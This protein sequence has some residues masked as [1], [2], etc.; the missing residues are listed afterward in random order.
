TGAY[1]DLVRTS[2]EELQELIEA[3][4]IPE[5]SFFRDRGAFAALRS[6]VLDRQLPNAPNEPLRILSVPCS[7]G[8]EPYT[9]AMTLLD[10][11][12][13]ATCARVDAVDISARALAHAKHGFF[14]ANA[15]RGADLAFRDRYFTPAGARYR[16]NDAVRALVQFQ[17]GNLLALDVVTGGAV[18]DVI[19]CRNLLIYF[20]APTQERAVLTLRRL[21][22]PGGLL[23]VGP[24]ETPAVVTHCFSPLG[25]PASFAFRRDDERC[26]ARQEPVPAPRRTPRSTKSART[27]APLRVVA[28]RAKA[29]S[30]PA[31]AA[32]VDLT[33]ATRLA[34]QGRL[35]EAA[36]ACER[37]LRANGP[38]AAAFHL[39]GLIHSA[40]DEPHAADVFF[41]KALYLEPRSAETLAHLAALREQLGD[42]AAARA[43]RVRLQ[44]L[45]RTGTEA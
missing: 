5:T 23:F 19:F 13:H 14:G 27:P 4:V 1:L 28:P 34:D 15:F 44:R 42:A 37:Y 31:A 10:A 16:V 18:Y 29:P 45:P 3:V 33:E 30:A 6:V 7:T 35:A 40:S 25:L 17:R 9:I 36:D 41:R 22:K 32:P 24:A 12:S 43:L 38:S 8:E 2:G 26:T 39:L 11:G 21:L 20:D